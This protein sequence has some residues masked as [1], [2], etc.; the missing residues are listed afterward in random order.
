MTIVGWHTDLGAVDGEGNPIVE[1]IPPLE[2][3]GSPTEIIGWAP[4]DAAEP[5][6]GRVIHDVDL[7][8]RPGVTG[9][10]QDVVDLPDG[11]YEVVGWPLDWTHGPYPY[12][13]GVIVQLK[14]VTG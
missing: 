7:Y 2:E 8:I 12:T 5:E 10:P 4:A 13:P 6:I 1:Y 11:Q 9:Q 14:R 3:P